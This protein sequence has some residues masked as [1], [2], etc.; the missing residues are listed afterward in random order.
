MYYKVYVDVLFLENLWMDLI[1]LESVNVLCDLQVNW[2]RLILGS[3]AG[4]LGA[5]LLTV[6][7]GWLSTAGYFAGTIILAVLMVCVA[8]PKRKQF[9][10]LVMYLYVTGFLFTGFLK[11]LNQFHPL[12]GVTAAGVSTVFG[13][14]VWCSVCIYRRFRKADQLVCSVVLK[15]GKA[16]VQ[17]EGLLDT[18]NTLYDPATGKAVHILSQ[19]L[20]EMLLQKSEKEMLPHLVLYHTIS[21]NGMLTAYILDEMEIRNHGQKTRIDRPMV[22]GRPSA[23]GNYP[24]ILHRDLFSL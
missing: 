2:K 12:A 7:S 20:L 1:L 5:C 9:G 16:L 8:F 3:A 19:D 4:S 14:I 15:A 24:L 13:L 10:Y 11:Y 17:T 21:Q 18:G 23:E 22:A 6:C